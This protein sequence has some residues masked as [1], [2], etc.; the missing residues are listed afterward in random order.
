MKK[1]FTTIALTGATIFGAN[2]QVTLTKTLPPAG[3]VYQA[4]S[5][6]KY[7]DTLDV[8]RPASGVGV[9]WDYS[10]YT[11]SDVTGGGKIYAPAAV[12]VSLQDSCPNAKYVEVLNLGAP[13]LS[14][15][16]L[17]I[18]GDE[19]DYL[20]RYLDKGSSSDT[21]VD[22]IRDTVFRFNQA[23]NTVERLHHYGSAMAGNIIA[24][25]YKYAGSGTLKIE[26]KTFTDVAMF[27]V[28]TFNYDFYFFTVTPFFHPVARV[29]ILPDNG[30]GGRWGSALFYNKLETGTSG[31]SET[32]NTLSFNAFPNPAKDVVTIGNVPGGSSVKVTDI[33]GKTVYNA[34]ISNKQTTINTSGFVNGVY[35][36]QVENNGT[37]AHSKLMI[38]K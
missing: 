28:D 37:V 23:F 18:Y 38:S 4:K 1:V 3:T 32:A 9:T 26:D 19:G 20:I 29:E 14:W 30:N 16:P 15:N 33:T 11:L 7:N 5:Y 8:P 27:T 22:P 36:I 10:A 24:Q 21:V 34:V 2:A 12:A 35:I 31:I 25:D 13:E 6:V 17:S